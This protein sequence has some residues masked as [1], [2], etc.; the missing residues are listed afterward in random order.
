MIN[1]N[2]VKLG[3]AP[4][5]WTNDDMPDLGGENTF[6][7]CVSEMA[8]AGFTGTEVGNKYPKDTGVLKKA[9]KMRN[10][11]VASAWFSSFLTTEPYKTT[12]KKFIEHRDFLSEMGADVIVVSEQGRSI[13]KANTPL[14]ESKPV[15]S[16]EEW[17]RL[18]NGLNHLGKLAQEKDMKIAFHHHMGTGVQTS[19]EVDKLMSLTASALVHLLYDSGHLY[20]SDKEA[21]S[22]LD[23][24]IDRIAHVHLKD[25]RDDIATK[26]KENKLTFK[27]AVRLGA[28][29]VPGDGTIDFQPIFEKLGKVDYRG[30][31]LVEAEQDPQRANPLEY[32]LFARRYIKETA[33]V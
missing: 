2:N 32:A 12:E 10:L 6:E 15:F 3:I 8:L 17:K 20:F 13:Q 5:A 14:F 27:D 1:K 26:I 11:E 25:V 23:K 22:L 9:L 18:S 4:I 19:E 31:L 21:V 7:Q 28:F 16:E 24:Y 30:W 33:G 29:T